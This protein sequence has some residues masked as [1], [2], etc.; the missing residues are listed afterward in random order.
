MPGKF[1][2]PAYAA[3]RIL[4]EIFVGS[5]EAADD[6]D[7][8]YAN[9]IS[10]VVNCC[11]HECLNKFQ[12]TGVRYLSLSIEEDGSSVLLDPE[13]VTIGRVVRFVSEGVDNDEGVLIFSTNG[14]SRAVALMAAFCVHRFHWPP[15]KA[16]RFVE[17]K[18]GACRIHQNY[19]Q[20]LLEF[21]ERRRR[22]YGD[23][24]DIF[25]DISSIEL[26]PEELLYRNTYLNAEAPLQPED[27]DKP[28]SPSKVQFS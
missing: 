16:L 12:A 6:D 21:A 1:K 11:R 24:K 19:V 5:R 20:Q 26:S 4:E 27:A 23:Y 15:A 7:F 17:I 3:S 8:I 28:T 10:K 18:R 9:T 25:D 22:R 13:D 14:D 2:K